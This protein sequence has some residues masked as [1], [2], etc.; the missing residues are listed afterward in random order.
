V[1]TGCSVSPALTPTPAPTETLAPAVGN[2]PPG[3]A[4]IDLRAPSG[5]RIELAGT[6]T[7]VD[8]TGQVMTWWIRTL[9]NC[10][11]G[12]GYIEDAPPEG[13]FEARPDHVQSLAGVL[14]SDFVITGEI[15]LLGALP[16][17]APGNPPRYSPLRI[18]VEFNEAGEILLRE[19]REP[20]VSGLRCPDPGGYCPAPLLL[21]RV[22]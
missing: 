8:T 7:E 21:Q 9:G 22:N 10:V 16:T 4:P 11:W 3:C 1:A 17:G 12:A 6:W 2:L 19:D 15:V 20:G 5:E 14:E 13:T 18:F